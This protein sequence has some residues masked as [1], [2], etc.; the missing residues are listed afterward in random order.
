MIF[1]F[2][3]DNVTFFEEDK[4]YF[5]KRF[6]PLKKFAGISANQ[7]E[8]IMTIIKVSKNKH[9]SGN[10]FESSVNMDCSGLGSFHADTSAD[11]IRKCADL[12]SSVLKSQ[13]KKA[14]D[15]KLG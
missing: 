11:N 13:I 1:Q 5:E 15:K 12:L 10:K 3:T 7:D 14:H 6:L 8:S 9:S 2:Q 4:E